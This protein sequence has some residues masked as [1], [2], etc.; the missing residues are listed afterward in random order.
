MQ[1]QLCPEALAISQLMII[2]HLRY[3][4]LK[5]SDNSI[6]ML[7]WGPGA[8]CKRTGSQ[9]GSPAG[10]TGQ[11]WQL[12][13]FLPPHLS[14][15]IMRENR[16]WHFLLV[17]PA[18]GTVLAIMF[19]PVES[20]AENNIVLLQTDSPV[21]SGDHGAWQHHSRAV[22]VPHLRSALGGRVFLGA[23][24]GWQC[25]HCSP[26][27]QACGSRLPSYTSL[28]QEER[29]KARLEIFVP[30]LLKSTFYD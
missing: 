15:P 29:K 13:G 16:L 9:A 25:Q 4:F 27:H 30:F 14:P 2:S 18:P 5:T 6:C 17:L 23:P 19:T 20:S 21:L 28:Y 10:R 22:V 8:Q 7:H 1:V 11:S 24:Q 3:H 12:H 26:I